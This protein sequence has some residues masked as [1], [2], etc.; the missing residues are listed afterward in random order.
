MY[1]CVCVCL[2]ELSRHGCVTWTWN[3]VLGVSW[4]QV[5]VL[6]VIKT[7]VGVSVAL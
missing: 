3:G 5:L 4:I 7:R 2:Y 6:K 1:V